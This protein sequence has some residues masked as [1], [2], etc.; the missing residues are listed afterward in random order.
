MRQTTLML[1]MCTMTGLVP[2]QTSSGEPDIQR[3]L[4]MIERG[5]GGLVEGE[6]PQLMT[7]YQNNPGVMY[8]QGVLTTDGTEAAKIYQSI[9]DNFP[10]SEWADDALF[11]LYQYYASVGLYKTAEQKLDQ[12]KLEYPFSTYA[13]EEPEA[14]P[15]SQGNAPVQ[16]GTEQQPE[17]P[18]VVQPEQ[19]VQKFSSTFT[20]Q[21]GAFSTM[22]NAETL[23]QRFEKEG[24]ASNIFTITRDG[25]KLH[26]VWVGEF[27][28]Q[29]D[30]RVFLG[31]VKKKFGLDA[32]VV[33]R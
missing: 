21:V 7:M 29:E 6:L 16:T 25:K 18:M 14:K 27:Q 5:Q 20:L 33:S 26:K 8:L 3:R 13:T 17:K 1:L 24:Y 19:P 4:E 11:R 28:N 9:I 2:A 12:L 32:I 23:K 31:E 15:L 22:E 10:K 30:A